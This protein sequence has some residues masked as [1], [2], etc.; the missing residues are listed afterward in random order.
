[1]T[2]YFIILPNELLLELSLYF[3]YRDT[4]LACDFLKCQSP[5]FWINKIRHELGYSNE[6][7]REYVFDN[8]QVKTLL[9]LNEKY[10]E[11]KARKGTDFGTEFY[12]DV[13]VLTMYASRLKDF[14]LADELIHYFLTINKEIY[15]LNRI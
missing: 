4:V 2:T 3:N 14:R 6:F 15:I 7:I 9:P 8:E 11:L 10:L 1:M 12:Q 5:Q 13:F